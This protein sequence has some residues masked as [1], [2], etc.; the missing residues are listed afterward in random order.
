MR[1][2][3]RELPDLGVKKVFLVLFWL[4]LAFLP[5]AKKCGNLLFFIS[6]FVYH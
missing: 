1:K 3:S 2:K 5:T 6:F 4:V